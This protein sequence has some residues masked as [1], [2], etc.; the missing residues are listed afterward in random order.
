M[1]DIK[2]AYIAWVLYSA[3]LF[4]T[5]INLSEVGRHR[6]HK[7]PILFIFLVIMAG[8]PMG[9]I[10]SLKWLV[11]GSLM[12]NKALLVCFLL[13]ISSVMALP[14]Y[15]GILFLGIMHPTYQGERKGFTSK[16]LGILLVFRYFWISLIFYDIQRETLFRGSYSNRGRDF[17][18]V[19]VLSY[20]LR[21]I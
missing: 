13:R 12:L 9:S 3:T 2:I 7:K 16:I 18:I 1:L 17:I 19:S 15:I 21:G 6:L 8:W 5:I 14:I 20:C 10:F 4:G 11:L